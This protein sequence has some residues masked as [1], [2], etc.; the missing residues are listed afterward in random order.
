MRVLYILT[1]S[2]A[3]PFHD[4]TRYGTE[5]D[6][7]FNE[8]PG[9]EVKRPAGGGSGGQVA[10]DFITTKH[11]LSCFRTI[12]IDGDTTNVFADDEHHFHTGA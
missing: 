10:R 12:S 11:C 7:F 5:Q 3:R 8:R 2:K 9:L 1:K 4:T 6:N